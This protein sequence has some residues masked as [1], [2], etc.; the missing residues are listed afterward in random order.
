[1]TI[2]CG[3]SD[4]YQMCLGRVN[5]RAVPY[6]ACP[7]EDERI[8]DELRRMGIRK[9]RKNPDNGNSVRSLESATQPLNIRKGI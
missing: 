6:D 9:C 5:G 1:M 8:S 2:R 4:K 3:Y 7:F